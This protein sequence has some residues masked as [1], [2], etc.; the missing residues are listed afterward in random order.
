MMPVNPPPLHRIGG[1]SRRNAE[2]SLDAADD[3]A[4]RATDHGADR[5]RGLSARLGAMRYAARNTL[6]LRRQRTGQR[7]NHR[8]RKY[9]VKLHA[10]TLSFVSGMQGLSPKIAAFAR[11]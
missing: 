11:R 10:T 6:R 1:V 7:G 2:Q 4:H 3:A 8:A 9:D 5:P